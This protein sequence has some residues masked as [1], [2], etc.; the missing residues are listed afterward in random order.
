M[1]RNHY[2][3]I[4]NEDF[5]EY[6]ISIDVL[7]ISDGKEIDPV[8]VYRVDRQMI[9]YIL[10]L[11]NDFYLS[12]TSST[13]EW[14]SRSRWTLVDWNRTVIDQTESISPL[15]KDPFEVSPSLFPSNSFCFCY[16]SMKTKLISNLIKNFPGKK[17]CKIFNTTWKIFPLNYFES[18]S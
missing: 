10:T 17:I 12:P 6:H 11:T 18:V 8:Y 7:F 14:S 3:V 5:W 4:F 1:W 9:R 15:T 2:L 16:I 13:L